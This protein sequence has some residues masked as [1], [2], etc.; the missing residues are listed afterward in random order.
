MK[1]PQNRVDNS[2]EMA[3]ERISELEKNEN[4]SFWKTETIKI[5]TGE[6]K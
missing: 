3:E 5:K 2:L 6:K 1:N 4:Y